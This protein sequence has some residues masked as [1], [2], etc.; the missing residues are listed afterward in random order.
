[1][2]ASNMVL[3]FINSLPDH[4][5]FTTREVLHF[6]SR[7]AIDVCLFKLVKDEKIRRL[8]RG[9]FVRNDYP[10]KF[11]SITEIALTKAASFGKKISIAGSEAAIRTG[12][13][14]REE[15]KKESSVV[16]YTTG[17]SSSFRSG[18]YRV[19]FIS[20]CPRKNNLSVSKIGD[21]LRGYWYMG[22]GRIKAPLKEL[23]RISK[24][25]LRTERELLKKMIRIM[26][27][28]MADELIPERK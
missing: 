20:A 16:Y 9:V 23:M 14:T 2:S 13:L 26:P 8:A 1:M 19:K 21:F 17:C 7:N 11:F 4:R 18:I 28:W 24:G 10:V 6:G 5:I 3:R 27:I 25:M 15:A 22:Q 12:L